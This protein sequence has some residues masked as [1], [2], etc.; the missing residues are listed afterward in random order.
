MKASEELKKGMNIKVE[1]EYFTAEIENGVFLIGCDIMTPWGRS[2]REIKPGKATGNSYLI[3]GS[4]KA[5]LIDSAA[6]IPGLRKKAEELAEVPVMFALS[7]AHFDHIY[8]LSEFDEFWI[9]KDD[10]C[11]LHG[12]YGAMEYPDIPK[13]I[14]FLEHGDSINLGGDRIID[15]FRIKGHTNGSLLF[16]DR[17]TKILFTG[18]SVARRLLYGTC[19]WVPVED[20]IR[21][22]K[23]V[24]K[25]DFTRILSAHDRIFLQKDHIDRMIAGFMKVPETKKRIFLP[26]MENEYIQVV[27]GNEYEEEFIDLSFPVIHR[28]EMIASINKIKLMG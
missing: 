15:V 9:H 28:D 23:E 3:V 26:I 19:S 24:K 12:A 25:L 22:L 7:H 8:D 10:E 5:L 16:L 4:E 27:E 13:N 17:Q 6:D 21:Q 1:G 11:L 2:G 18:D 14:H 20:Y